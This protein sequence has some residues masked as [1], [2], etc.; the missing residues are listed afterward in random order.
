[1]NLSPAAQAIDKSINYLAFLLK[2]QESGDEYFESNYEDRAM[3]IVF[4]FVDGGF[5][6]LSASESAVNIIY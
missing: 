2:N 5:L 4:N 6:R 1:M 3:D